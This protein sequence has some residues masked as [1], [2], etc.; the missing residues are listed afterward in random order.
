M[1]NTQEQRAMK[2]KTVTLKD[3]TL[4]A[5]TRFLGSCQYDQVAG[6]IQQIANEV[7]PQIQARQTPKPEKKP[8]ES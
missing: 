8:K 1:T 3:E 5:I 2:N 4:D 6:L 7:A